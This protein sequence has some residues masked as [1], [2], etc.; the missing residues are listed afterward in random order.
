MEH[1][2]E[3]GTLV[4]RAK[5]RE[6]ALPPV[7]DALVIGRNAPIGAEA[8][9]RALK[10]LHVNTFEVVQIEDGSIDTVL[11]RVGVLRKIPRDKLVT[12]IKTRVLP[13]MSPDE[14]I[15]LE[16]EAELSVEDRL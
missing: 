12:F 10:L 6:F 2:P 14:V 3:S 11:V 13:F 15:H 1:K 8:L 9:S 5:L 4:V 7:E 16:L